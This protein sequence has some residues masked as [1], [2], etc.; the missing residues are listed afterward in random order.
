MAGNRKDQEVRKN[1]K[2]DTKKK[3]DFFPPM[4]R[5]KTEIKIRQM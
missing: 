3:T 4:L 1:L 2:R 5:K